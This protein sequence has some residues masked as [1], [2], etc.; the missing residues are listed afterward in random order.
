MNKIEKRERILGKGYNPEQL[1]AGLSE[2]ELMLICKSSPEIASRLSD[3]N[4]AQMKRLYVV[5]NHPFAITRLRSKNRRRNGNWITHVLQRGRRKAVEKATEE[6]LIDYLYDFYK[7]MEE[8][9]Y[10]YEDIFQD[11]VK[12]KKARGRSP[13]TINEYFRYNAFLP[14]EIRKTP[15]ARIK[16]KEL[17]NWLVHDYLKTNPRKEALKKVIQQIRAVFAYGIRTKNCSDNP[18]L[19][20][21]CEDYYKYCDLSDRLNEQ[22]SFSEREIEKL[23]KLCL[24][25]SKNPHSVAMLVA[26]ETGMRVAELTSLKKEDVRDGFIFVHRQQIRIIKPSL[27]EMNYK[28]V[29]YTKNERANPKGGRLIPITEKCQE[30]LKMADDLR[31]ESEYVFHHPNGNPILKDSYMHYLKRKCEK[32]GIPITNN[33]A[34]RVA[35][36]ARLIAAGIDGN[37]RC[38]VLGHSMQTNERN[39]SFSDKRKANDIRDKLNSLAL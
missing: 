6:E 33:H 9:P 4:K 32:L 11:F 16:E 1:F 37:D 3:M 39:Y 17:V 31:G 18:A 20:I 2:E 38:L 23:R 15:I 12:S 5:E 27:G 34:F 8:C 28:E 29:N 22:R 26:M 30:A 36:N 19:N 35:F 13:N 24:S 14:E 21:I 10:T 25:Q 7:M